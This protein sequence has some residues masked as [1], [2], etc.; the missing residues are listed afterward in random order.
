M[1][2]KSSP[3]RARSALCALTLIGVVLGPGGCSSTNATHVRGSS[4]NLNA[5][6]PNAGTIQGGSQEQGAIAQSGV[7]CNQ[8]DSTVSCCLK[9][10][11][12]EYE[13]CGATPPTQRPNDPN[14]LPPPG[15]FEDKSADAKERARRKELC[16]DHYARCI[17]QGGED[18]ERGQWGSTQCQS[19]YE[20]C[21]KLGYWPATW[22]DKPCPGGDR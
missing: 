17:L 18:I 7:E 9:K 22:D 15:T 21:K 14:R 2:G 16:G 19:C 5:L 12:G 10:H 11:P 20:E 13:R 4:G 1:H 3:Q 8:T 6:A